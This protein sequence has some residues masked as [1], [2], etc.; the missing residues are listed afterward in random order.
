MSAA[1]KD[2]KTQVLL[3][4]VYELGRQPYGLASAAAWIE[5]LD[6]TLRCCDTSVQSLDSQAIADADFIGL[7]IPMHTALRI[8]MSL[9]PRV[10]SLNPHAHICTYGLYAPANAE[11]LLGLG[12]SSVLGGEF[13]SQLAELVGQLREG[14]RLEA[15]KVF[16]PLAKTAQRVAER[17]YLPPLTSYGHL[18]TG[19]NTSRVVGNTLTSRGCKH[20][21]GH[22]PVAAVYNGKVIIIAQQ[23]VLADIEQ[24]V[25]AGAEHNTFGDDDFFNAP[26]H[27]LRIIEALHQRH[28]SLSY[29]ATIKIEHILQH[30]AVLPAL[31][32]T[33]CRFITCAIESFEDRVLQ[34]LDKGHSRADVFEATRLLREQGIALSPTFIPFTPW[35]SLSGYAELLQLIAELGWVQRVSSVQLALRLLIPK[36]SLLLDTKE[37]RELVQPFDRKAATY[38][39]RHH[40]P[41][42]D[43]L[44]ASI[45]KITQEATTEQQSRGDTFAQIWKQARSVVTDM[46][47]VKEKLPARALPEYPYLEEPW[48][49]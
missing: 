46:P 39:W 23:V 37:V 45:L 16:Q 47:P 42:L 48:Y 10:R 13:E 3:I 29:D 41:R 34:R 27:A 35:T 2:S 9:L 12:A 49:C 28:P 8:V 21:C 22:C 6:V 17:K 19:P 44:A 20:H 24:Q 40:D 36:H 43:E 14:R 32:E 4:G 15:K 26:Q 18:R 5:P 30:K 25:R 38:P 11:L 7:C 33:G 31:R 1:T